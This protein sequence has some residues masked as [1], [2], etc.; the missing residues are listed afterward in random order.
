MYTHTHIQVINDEFLQRGSDEKQAE[1][2]SRLADYYMQE[3]NEGPRVIALAI[4]THLTKSNRLREVKQF[5]IKDR[6]F[7]FLMPYLR[8]G[9]F[10]VSNKKELF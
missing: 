3:Q 10:L 6:R 2:H 1:L 5:L 7:N 9:M 4:P 8:S